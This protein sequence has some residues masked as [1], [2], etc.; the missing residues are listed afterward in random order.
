MLG[1]P[2]QYDLLKSQRASTARL[3]MTP[4]QPDFAWADEEDGVLAVKHG[5]DI[6]YASLYWRARTAVNFLARVHEITPHF[7]RIAVVHEETNFSPSG[8]T[9]ERPDWVNM[10]FGN[11]GIKYPGNLHSAETGEPLPIAKFPDGNLSLTD[12][13]NWTTFKPGQESPFAG[14]GSFYQLQYGNYLIGMNC[15]KDK[16]YALKIPE[17]VKDTSAPDLISGQTLDLATGV[18]VAP[19]TTVILDLSK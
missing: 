11:G 4:G 15:T 12:G 13:A 9:Y 8:L 16:T 3:P 1:I 19:Q 14:R 6:F 10:G 7:D 2:D 18:S 5:E 17:S